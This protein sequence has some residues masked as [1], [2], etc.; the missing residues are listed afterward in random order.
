MPSCSP[1]QSRAGRHDRCR[2]PQRLSLATH[3]PGRT[4]TPGH[5][6]DPSLHRLPPLP[7]RRNAIEGEQ[8]SV[9]TTPA[10]AA[11][12]SRPSYSHHHAEFAVPPAP[13][14]FFFLA[15]ISPPLFF[16]QEQGHERRRRSPQPSHLSS[17]PF[18]VST[19]VIPSTRPSSH[20][21]LSLPEPSSPRD[22]MAAAMAARGGPPSARFPLP[23]VIGMKPPHLPL[24]PHAL[25][26][27]NGG[28]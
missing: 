26:F 21:S 19:P 10:P 13:S 28:P 12:K 18:T 17:I 1:G 14:P 4:S 2:A 3:A 25:R 6:P 15:S 5:L 11:Y 7:S 23:G 20:P 9:G 16:E 24:S 27:E 8:A 22:P